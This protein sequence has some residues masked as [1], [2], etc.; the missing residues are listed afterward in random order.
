MSG[1]HSS[2]SLIHRMKPN[3]QV[4]KGKNIFI[5]III[6]MVLMALSSCDDSENPAKPKPD[7]A[8]LQAL[9]DE[10]ILAQTKHFTVDATAIGKIEGNQGTI[11][12]FSA[13]AFLTQAG[14]AVTGNVDIELI[15]IYS[16]SSMLLTQKATIGKKDD[17]TK[18]M[19]ISGGEFYVNATQGGNILKPASGYSIIVPTN[20]TG[21]PDPE[22]NMFNGVVECERDTC[23]LVWEEQK[24]RKIEIGEFQDAGGVFSAYYAFQSKFGWTNIDRWYNDPRTKTTIFV[25]VPEGFDNT[26]CAVYI[27]YDGE[28]TAL[29]REK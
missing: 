7:A 27:V 12:Q 25:E 5:A 1:N 28:P 10:N 4:M 26:N 14:G 22:M 15:E 8:A 21:G 19:L 6:S 29:G 23:K 3:P 9:T 18:A 11:I 20:N 24:D 2:W 17:G 13:N 16:R